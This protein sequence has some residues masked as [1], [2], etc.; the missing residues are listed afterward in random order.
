MEKEKIEMILDTHKNY[1]N[2]DL[3]IRAFKAVTD[4]YSQ[5]GSI[6]DYYLVPLESEGIFKSLAATKDV[7]ERCGFYKFLIYLFN[8]WIEDSEL[9]EKKFDLT[10][11]Y[12]DETHYIMNINNTEVEFFLTKPLEED[13]EVYTIIYDPRQSYGFFDLDLLNDLLKNNSHLGSFKDYT[14]VNIF[15][16]ACFVKT[17]EFNK[18]CIDDYET[19]LNY[20]LNSD[21]PDFKDDI[22]D[23][24]VYDS[25]HYQIELDYCLLEVYEVTPR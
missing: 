11:K 7:T 22:K 23:I 12:V 1:G 8:G 19:F 16:H 10:V 6:L 18:V 17:E 14:M 2:E 9:Y 5:L 25:D 4:K 15:D 13:K 3:E 21:N 20:A 24:R